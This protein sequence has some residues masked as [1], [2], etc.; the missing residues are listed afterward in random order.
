MTFE[1][2]Y[3]NCMAA[4]ASANTISNFTIYKYTN[5]NEFNSL[6]LSITCF[7][8]FIK[9]NAHQNPNMANECYLKLSKLV[10]KHPALSG[11]NK[12]LLVDSL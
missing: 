3:K 1:L 4:I 2:A 6:L 8:T 5:P 9:Q 11:L 7:Y 10:V 12:M